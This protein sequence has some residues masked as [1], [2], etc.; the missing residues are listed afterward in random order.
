[1]NLKTLL[2]LSPGT[3]VSH[4]K[5]TA[6]LPTEQ[7]PVPEKVILPMRQPAKPAFKRVTGCLWAPWWAGHPVP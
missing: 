7:L 4:H 5:E 6:N 2:W 1:M 3:Q